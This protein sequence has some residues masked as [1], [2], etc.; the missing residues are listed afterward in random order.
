MANVRLPCR[1]F[2]ML[3][4]QVEQAQ[5]RA[6]GLPSAF[7]PKPLQLRLT[8]VFALSLPINIKQN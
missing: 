7:L 1:I 6:C 8:E 4:D 5:G 2:G 3:A